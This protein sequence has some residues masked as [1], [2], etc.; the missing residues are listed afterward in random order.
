VRAP[1]DQQQRENPL[2]PSSAIQAEAAGAGSATVNEAATALPLANAD[3]FEP[4]GSRACSVLDAS[5]T[6]GP[7]VDVTAGAISTADTALLTSLDAAIKELAVTL[8]AEEKV[9]Q[10]RRRSSSSMA[11]ALAP[12]VLSGLSDPTGSAQPSL[13]DAPDHL[14]LA[15]PTID[16][17][18][19]VRALTCLEVEASEATR[20]FAIQLLLSP[21]PI[22]PAQVPNLGLFE[23]Y[24]L[25]LVMGPE[26]DRL[27]Y[28]LRLGFFSS[29]VAA[30]AVVRYLSGYFPTAMIKRVSIA[31]RER[32]ADKIITA[33]K[34]IGADGKR[35]NIEIVT[36]PM[37]R[38]RHLSLP[39]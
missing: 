25:Y 29:A 33:G 11:M 8:A 35:L 24:S 18:Q 36:A 6:V 13:M 23:E 1:S 19:T 27:T 26:Q 9:V 28:A 31:E 39:H 2:E 12:S 22:E 30:A 34:D 21:R 5:A 7:A 17:T 10:A 20:W 15:P 16:S 38:S 37:R 3:T 4:S 32:F 14:R